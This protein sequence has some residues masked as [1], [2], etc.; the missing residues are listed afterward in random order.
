[1][2]E[3]KAVYALGPDG[4]TGM[5]RLEWAAGVVWAYD[6]SDYLVASAFYRHGTGWVIVRTG[7]REIVSIHKDREGAELKLR[8]MVG[9]RA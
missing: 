5:M 9:G 2:I 3:S 8:K 1:M 4:I 7:I 6:S